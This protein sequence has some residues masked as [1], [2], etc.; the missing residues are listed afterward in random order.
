MNFYNL[1]TWVLILGVF[2]VFMIVPEKKRQKK[3]R[4]MMESLNI[5]DKILT[6]GG[7]YGTISSMDGDRIVIESGPDATRIEMAKSAV[8]TVISNDAGKN[9]EENKVEEKDE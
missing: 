9:E 2:Y 3:M 1:I 6:R 5:G 7:I 4:E 8:L